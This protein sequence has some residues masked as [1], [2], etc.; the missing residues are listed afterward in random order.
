MNISYTIEA[1]LS[2]AFDILVIMHYYVGMD[3]KLNMKQLMEIAQT[4]DIGLAQLYNRIGARPITFEV[5]TDYATWR[6]ETAINELSH[7][8][9]VENKVHALKEASG[10]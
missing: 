10:S 1:G 7:W 3:E 9:D 4:M 8:Q 6:K 2:S 5:L